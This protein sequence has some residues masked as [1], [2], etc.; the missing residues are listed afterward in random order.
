MTQPPALHNPYVKLPEACQIAR[1]S[2]STVM[3]A[4]ASGDLKGVQ[5]YTRTHWSIP[6][7]ELARWIDAGCP[8]TPKTADETVRAAS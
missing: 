3:R 1:R 8:V 6:R 7:D 4:L 5:P 2:R